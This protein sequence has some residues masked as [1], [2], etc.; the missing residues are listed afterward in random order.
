[1][2][3]A[4]CAEGMLTAA[5]V[6]EEIREVQEALRGKAV[7]IPDGE[8]RVSVVDR[9]GLPENVTLTV[10]NYRW[11]K[12]VSLRKGVRNHR[13]FVIPLQFARDRWYTYLTTEPSGAAE[14][15]AERQEE[16]RAGTVKRRGLGGYGG[17][18]EVHR[19]EPRGADAQGD[20]AG[21][22]RGQRHTG[23]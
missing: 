13:G 2:K 20:T 6:P 16:E 8:A 7:I 19:G 4:L 5:D 12:F 3:N 1:M 15:G 18:G 21:V 23:D 11:W 10:G 17:G 14:G 22:Q 9:V